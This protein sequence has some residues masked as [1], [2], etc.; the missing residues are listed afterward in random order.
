[1]QELP[2]DYPR[3]PRTLRR[4]LEALEMAGFPLVNEPVAPL[5]LAVAKARWKHWYRFHGFNAVA[6]L[7]RAEPGQHHAL[8]NGSHGLKPRPHCEMNIKSRLSKGCEGFLMG[9]KISAVM[10]GEEQCRIL[11]S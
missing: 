9:V 7:K 11:H 8:T 6:P 1:M 10:N 4:D 2:A 3:H 5:K